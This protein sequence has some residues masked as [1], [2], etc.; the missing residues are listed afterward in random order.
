MDISQTKHESKEILIGLIKEEI[1]KIDNTS[2]KMEQIEVV[3][4][5]I[6]LLN[7]L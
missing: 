4:G 3:L 7:S 2:N 5:L 6:T 1:K